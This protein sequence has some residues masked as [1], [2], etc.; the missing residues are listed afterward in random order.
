[1]L[2]LSKLPKICWAEACVTAAYVLNRA[3]K[4]SVDNKSLIELWQ[5]KT[6]DNLDHLSIFGTEGFAHIPKQ[7]RRKFDNEVIKKYLVG[8]VNNRHGYHVY[9]SSKKQLQLAEMS[10]LNQNTHV[11]LVSCYLKMCLL[12]VWKILKLLLKFCSKI[13]FKA[14]KKALALLS[15]SNRKD[16]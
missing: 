12:T 13:H 8:Y 3:G 11:R 6:Y 4:S 2:A 7:N 16:C 15:W 5:G 9:V 14:R 1:M 10:Y